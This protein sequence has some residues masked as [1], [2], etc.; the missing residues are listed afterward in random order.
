[1]PA[2]FEFDDPGVKMTVPVVADA[3]VS[4]ATNPVTAPLKRG[5][6]PHWN[7]ETGSAT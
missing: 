6:G 5:N 4:P 1:M 3:S 7:V 2:V